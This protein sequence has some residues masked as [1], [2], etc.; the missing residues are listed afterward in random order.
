MVDVGFQLPGPADVDDAPSQ[1][2]FRPR[3]CTGPHPASCADARQ[4]RYAP[5]A[6]E[7]GI[8]SGR[9]LF[10]LLTI[11]HNGSSTL[12]FER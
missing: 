5:Q 12:L 11:S 10:C 3:V 8:F 1:T 4:K 6:P 7:I 2:A 9:L